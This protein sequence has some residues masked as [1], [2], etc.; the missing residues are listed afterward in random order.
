[1]RLGLALPLSGDWATPDNQIFV[2]QRAEALGFLE[3][4]FQLGGA[5]LDK[6]LAVMEQLTPKRP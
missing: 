5:H 4:N 6:V 3:P 2:A 1:M